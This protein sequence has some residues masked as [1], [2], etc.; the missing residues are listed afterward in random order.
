MTPLP[1]KLN[2][3]LFFGGNCR[4]AMEFYQR[5]FG[6]ELTLSPF[7]ESPEGAHKD[8]KANSEEVKNKIMYAKLSGDVE[9]LASDNPHNT[10]AKNTGQFS[11]SLEGADEEKL[12][13]YFDKLSENG[14]VTSPLQKQFWGDTFGM[15]TDQYG[16][17]WMMNITA[18]Q[19]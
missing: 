1:I 18:A 9:L 17:N 6:G 15:V 19:Q 2:P 10:D 16:I 14:Q 5:V 12:S 8:P 3:Y 13:G 4:E 11:L 7:S